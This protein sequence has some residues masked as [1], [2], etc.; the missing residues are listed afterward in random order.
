MDTEALR[1]FTL[2]CDTG[3]F[4]AAAERLHLTQPAVSKRI[5]VLEQ[6][7]GAKLFD[8][9]SRGVR[10]TEAGKE[11]E[12]RAR[13]I[14]F[15]L[16]D[17]RRA[18]ANL[19]RD[20]SG[21]LSIATS[22][23]IG[24]WRLPPILHKYSRSHPDV[25]LDL[26]FMD[27][28]VGYDRI[29]RGELEIGVITLAPTQR[30]LITAVPIWVDNLAIVVSKEHELA[31]RK[32]ATLE[33]LS[34]FPSILPDVSTFTGRIMRALFNERDLDL[35][36]SI[37][38]NYLETIKMLISIGIGWSV[39]PTTMLDLSCHR[40]LI[41]G[42]DISRQLGFIYHSQRTISNAGQA[43]VDLLAAESI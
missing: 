20:I 27:S 9:I 12:P 28:E 36:I 5:A 24:L 31:S 1:A 11:M 8:R 30:D 7:V 29:L 19:S 6:Q 35:Q 10:L 25:A 4:S 3:S 21:R 18:I 23:H 33:E 37:S 15:N 2:I 40:L 17:G 39:L 26:H 42:I 16:D 14:L 34:A 41:E 13:Q 22:H 43:F 32:F 38:T